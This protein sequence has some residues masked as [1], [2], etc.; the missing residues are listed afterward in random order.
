M[1]I[2]GGKD[3]YDG[4]GYGLVDPNILFHRKPYY[5]EN[6]WFHDRAYGAADIVTIFVAGK[7]YNCIDRTFDYNIDALNKA[8][9]IKSYWWNKTNTLFNFIGNKDKQDL[10]NKG[11]VTAIFKRGDRQV[12]VNSA[13]LN[14]YQLGKVLPPREAFQDIYQ[15]VDAMNVA[16]QKELVT[17]SNKER[18]VKAGFDLKQSFRGN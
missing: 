16:K 5:I 17:L 9:N 4:A 7:V 8:C 14:M 2:I 11:V 1:R 10:F 12:L 6:K 15:W 18:I 13:Q 3:Y